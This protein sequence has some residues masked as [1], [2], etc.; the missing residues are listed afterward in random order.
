MKTTFTAR[1]F[2]ASPDLQSYSLNAVEKL[3]QFYDNI[4]MCDIR[5]EP[6]NKEEMPHKAELSIQV[7]KQLLHATEE[8]ASFEQAINQ[9]V[10]NLVRQIRKYKSKQFDK[11]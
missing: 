1:H 4:Q 3:T 5:L 7:P 2:D 10:D 6:G 9:A 11:R 8:A